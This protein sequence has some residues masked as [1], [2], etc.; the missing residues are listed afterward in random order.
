MKH[1]EDTYI[2]SD[3]CYHKLLG[4]VVERLHMM[5]GDINFSPTQ[6]EWVSDILTELKSSKIKEGK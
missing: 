1:T 3:L 5:Q 6:I 2:I 4:M